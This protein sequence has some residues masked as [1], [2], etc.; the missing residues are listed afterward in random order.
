MKTRYR[1]FRRGNRGGAYYCV[2]TKTN[3]RTSLKTSNEE[4]AR[5]IILAK[6]QAERQPLLNMQIAKAY[7][8][9]SDN[10][11]SKRSWQSVL[12]IIIA[13]K[14]GS[15]QIRWKTAAN[16]K[17]FNLIRHRPIIETTGEDFLQVLKIGTVS[18]NVHLRKMHN[19]CL[20]M[21]WLPW[22]IL[23]IKQWPAIRYGE[24]RA[25]TLDEHQAILKRERNPEWRTFYALLW[26]VGGSQ[27][28]VATLC[29]ENI[30]WEQRVI[31]YNR[32]KTGSVSHFRFGDEVQTI[33]RELP[34]VGTLFPKIAPRH[35][36]HRAKE[37]KRRCEGLNIKGVSLHS[38]RYAWA[39]RARAVGYPERFAM[40][41]LG[42]NSKAVHWAYAKRAQ[43]T[44]PSLEEYES[45]SAL[46]SAGMVLDK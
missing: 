18:T 16:D 17:A 44:V 40:E 43:V 35:E 8:A 7:L 28:D 38:Y 23:P 27:T 46:S 41:N 5:Q 15:S 24:K 31:S 39:E 2:D 20:G 12:D 14:Q 1:L 3:T 33:L 30:D 29:A 6:N 34:S 45:R 10:G 11:I 19:Y 25:I 22:P 36:K 21:G 32:R 4:E 37:F 13:T 26:H 42:H 9:G